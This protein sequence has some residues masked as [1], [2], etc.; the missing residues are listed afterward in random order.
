ML[1]APK[2]K[3]RNPPDEAVCFIGEYRQIVLFA[4]VLKAEPRSFSIEGRV[5]ALYDGAGHPLAPRFAVGPQALAS[6]EADHELI[7]AE[8][9]EAGPVRTTLRVRRREHAMAEKF[10]PEQR[11]EAAENLGAVVR[12][13]GRL[14]PWQINFWA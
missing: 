2:M 3:P 11:A 12:K 1:R 10:T 14:K 6:L 5:V 9:D 4:P 8:T 7:V 13:G